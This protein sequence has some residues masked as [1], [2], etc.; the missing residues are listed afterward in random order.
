MLS[1]GKAPAKGFDRTVLKVAR[2]KI[3]M[4]GAATTL[5]DLKVPRA[6]QLEALKKDRAGQHSIRVND[7]YRICFTW[8]SDGAYDVEFVDYH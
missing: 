3:L 2:R 1:K 6:N 7:Q 4:I 8:K 5:N